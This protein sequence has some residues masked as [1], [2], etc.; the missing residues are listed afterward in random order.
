[1]LKEIKVFKVLLEFQ[2]PKV[3]K[4][5]KA[6]PDLLDLVSMHPTVELLQTLLRD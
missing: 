3:H 5:P 2:E 6:Q 4:D 1:V